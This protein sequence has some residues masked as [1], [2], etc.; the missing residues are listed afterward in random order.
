VTQSNDK[1]VRGPPTLSAYLL[2]QNKP[3]SLWSQRQAS[4]FKA[5]GN[6]DADQ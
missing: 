6:R 4:L 1:Q 2:P 3:R 5:E